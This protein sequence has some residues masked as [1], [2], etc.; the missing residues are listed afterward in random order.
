MSEQDHR[1][2]RLVEF[3]EKS[4]EYPIRQLVRPQKPRSNT[5][6]CDL[7]LDQGQEGACVGF[8]WSHELAADPVACENITNET[9]LEVY[10][11]AQKL[12]DFSGED[13]SG[14]SVLAGAKAVQAQG[15]MT[16]YRWAFGLDD[17]VLALGNHGPAVLGINWYEGMYEPDEKGFI[18]VTGNKVGGHAILAQ[19]VNVEERYVQL[20]NS[21][22]P[23]WGKNGVCYISFD[24][25]DRLLK[26]DGEA[27]VPVKREL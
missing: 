11:E 26:E 10:H 13:Y 23:D 24:D 18:H 27:C 3:D 21:W 1:L 20:H 9:A 19:G 22:G 14:T 4:R 15:K 16:E 6:A 8:S 17:L 5:W 12:D 25:L 2:D 7:Y